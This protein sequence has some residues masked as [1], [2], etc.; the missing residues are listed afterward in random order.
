MSAE[1]NNVLE[2][3]NVTVEAGNRHTIG[4]S[5]ISL[6]LTRGEAILIT[7]PAA[8]R[9]TLLNDLI[10]GMEPP[11]SGTVRFSGLLWSER[12]AA[13]VAQAKGRI[14]RV[15]AD[16]AWIGNLDIDENI[17]MPQLYH[18]QRTAT[19]IR[20][21]ANDLAQSFGLEELPRTRPAWTPKPVQQKAQWVRALLGNPELL[22]LE[23]P[24]ENAGE[25]DCARLAAAVDQ[26]RAKGTAALWIT[27][28]SAP[29]LQEQPGAVR[30]AELKGGMLKYKDLKPGISIP[31]KDNSYG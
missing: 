25:A 5:N 19:E 4:V 26:A 29:A 8:E 18:T 15:W 30:H 27:T 14:G 1:K 28:R 31:G 12:N 3:Q 22:L 11:S 21:E 10:C 2:L 16:V 23:Y 13:Q 20:E 24:A 9:S 6:C 7:V 17:L